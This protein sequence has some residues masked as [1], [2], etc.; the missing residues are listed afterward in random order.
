LKVRTPD[1]SHLVN[2]IINRPDWSEGNAIV[3]VISG[4][5]RRVIEA[6][7]SRADE[8]PSV[9]PQLEVYFE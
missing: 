8:L 2:G 5:G 6:F 7:D 9:P 4:E 1:L 3:F